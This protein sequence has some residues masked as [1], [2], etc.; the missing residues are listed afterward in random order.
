M[1]LEEGRRKE[2][3]KKISRL[4]YALH[5]T[6]T[7]LLAILPIE[8]NSSKFNRS[9]LENNRA[10]NSKTWMKEDTFVIDAE[11][12]SQIKK[13]NKHESINV[14]PKFTTDTLGASSSNQIWI[15]E[16]VFMP[17]EKN[18]FTI[19]IDS[20]ESVGLPDSVV[21]KNAVVK[22]LK[23]IKKLS[24]I[25]EDWLILEYNAEQSQR[26]LPNKIN[27]RPKEMVGD[28][29]P[30]TIMQIGD[31]MYKVTPNWIGID[32]YVFN[33]SLD[34][35]NFTVAAGKHFFSKHI[36][37]KT[38]IKTVDEGMPRYLNKVRVFGTTI[39]YDGSKLEKIPRAYQ[40]QAIENYKKNINIKTED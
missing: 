21:F 40:K 24:E 34:G 6:L 38:V 10:A 1:G 12:N 28:H 37:F 5:M 4:T 11:D 39:Q 16:S 15:A 2:S 14:V 23:S 18:I 13:H 30:Y 9:D 19:G 26:K 36:T 27:F 32:A 22:A 7:W 20:K 35:N 17:E 8:I 29:V 31:E 3:P 33:M 25:P